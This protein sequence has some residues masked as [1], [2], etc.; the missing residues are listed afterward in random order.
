[1]RTALLREAVENEHAIT[2]I[3]ET[4]RTGGGVRGQ[5]TVRNPDGD[6]S[7]REV[8]GTDCQE[9][10]SAMALIAALM[11]D[12]LA[13]GPQHA[14]VK[15]KSAALATAPP[16]ATPTLWSLRAEQRLT[17]RSAIAPQLAWGQGL[18]LMVT[19]ESG[20]LRPSLA[21][22]VLASRATAV[23]EH[24]A[25]E[26]DWAAGQLTLCP[27]GRRPGQRWDVRA[28]AALQL[29]RLR[30]RGFQTANRGTK[31]IV[32]S[33]AALELQARYQLLEPLWLGLELGLSK[34]FTRE[35]FYL[36]PEET[37]HRVPAWGWNAGLGVG[38]RFL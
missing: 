21:L 34:P 3:V 33:S 13:G 14:S 1:M 24:G 28:C 22:S 17:L 32:W 38:V 18:G 23:A 29:G 31:S 7:V 26:L 35:R 5:L 9:V 8:P 6:L 37:L 27:V 36:L 11:V 15:G 30:G 4:F 2:L 12:P 20:A 19:R 10:A 16:A 25:A